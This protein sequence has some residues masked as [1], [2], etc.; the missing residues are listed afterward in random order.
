MKLSKRQLRRIIR[1]EKQ[2]ILN[3]HGFDRTPT[4]QREELLMLATY[5]DET[6]AYFEEKIAQFESVMEDTHPDGLARQVEDVAYRLQVLAR[7][8]RNAA[9]EV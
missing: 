7:N 2:N 6:L 4:S 1:E 9:K 3:E 8:A 5:A